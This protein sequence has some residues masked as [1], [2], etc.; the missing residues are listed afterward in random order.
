MKEQVDII[1]NLTQ[2]ELCTIITALKMEEARYIREENTE[3]KNL[4]DAALSAINHQPWGKN[5]RAY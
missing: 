2:S 1:L 5:S 4:I 3:R